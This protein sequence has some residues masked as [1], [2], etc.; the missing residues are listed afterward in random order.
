MHRHS[1]DIYEKCAIQ[2]QS[3]I[4]S[5][6]K[7]QYGFVSK[8]TTYLN[9]P[10]HCTTNLTETCLSDDTC[11]RLVVVALLVLSQITKEYWIILE[12]PKS[13]TGFRRYAGGCSFLS[14]AIQTE[15]CML[16]L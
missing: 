11:G 8:T 1:N 6:N 15:V 16:W 2:Q 3:V 4:V 14:V 5:I 10:R 7:K 9:L 13:A 12:R